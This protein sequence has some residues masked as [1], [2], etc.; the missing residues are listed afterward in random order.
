MNNFS[1]MF[2]N[3]ENAGNTKEGNFWCVHLMISEVEVA[4]FGRFLLNIY[5]MPT[6]RSIFWPSSAKYERNR[7]YFTCF[8]RELEN[9]KENNFETIRRD[10]DQN[11]RSQHSII[12]T[13]VVKH[14]P[15]DVILSHSKLLK[16]FNTGATLLVPYNRFSSP[17]SDLRIFV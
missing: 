6:F 17:K 11:S 4:S 16:N 3:I 5:F 13:V 2:S 9:K 7:I 1:T 10:F 8:F 12:F 14:S 15:R